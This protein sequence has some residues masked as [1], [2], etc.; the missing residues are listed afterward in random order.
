MLRRHIGPESQSLS[1]VTRSLLAEAQSSLEKR[2]RDAIVHG[3][4]GFL[5]IALLVYVL[6]M[7]AGWL[8]PETIA[9]WLTLKP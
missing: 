4:F 9:G 6:V 2:L 3:A 8:T 5:V 1:P 7:W